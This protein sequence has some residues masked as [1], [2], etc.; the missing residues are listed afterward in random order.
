MNQK[1]S[2]EKKNA[3][4]LCMRLLERKDYTKKEMKDHLFRAGCSE[5]EV[6]K[7]IEDAEEQGYLD[8]CRY[9]ENYVRTYA[10]RRSFVRIKNDLIQRGIAKELIEEAFSVWEEENGITK[11]EEEIRQI[12]RRIE[13]MDFNWDEADWKE[14]QKL[15]ASFARKG[16]GEEAIRRAASQKT[17]S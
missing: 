15:M 9:A 6:Q 3:E 5:E 16:Y 13:Q 11:E 1:P 7:A 12:R 2:H 4:A 10:E 14:R 8:D 17:I